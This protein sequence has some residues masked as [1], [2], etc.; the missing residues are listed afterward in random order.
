M[1]FTK[2][3]YPM[4]SRLDSRSRAALVSWLFIYAV[5]NNLDAGAFKGWL[6][7]GRA[8]N[9]YGDTRA[10]RRLSGDIS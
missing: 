4:P 3:N 6:T 5:Q 9:P 1:D 8:F 10:G 7:A 2:E